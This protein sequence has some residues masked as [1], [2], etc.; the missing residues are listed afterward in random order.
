[1]IETMLSVQGIR[2]SYGSQAVLH[3]VSLHVERSERLLLIGANGCG[4]TTLLKVIAG[5][6]RPE[7]GTVRLEGRDITRLP[8]DE[9]MRE[10]MGFLLQARNIFPSLSV[11]ENMLLAFWNGNDKFEER[12]DCLLKAF[13]MIQNKL[14]RRAGL[15]SGG[16]RQALA[17]AMTLMRPVDVL[18][19]DEP[20]AGLAPKAA[21][22]ILDAIRVVQ[23]SVGFTTIMVEHNLRAV[24]RWVSRFVAMKHGKI[25]GEESDVSKLLDHQT[26]QRYYFG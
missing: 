5:A 4:K 15:L 23:A 20:T 9:R 17:I 14:N 13:P 7:A 16:E 21:A 19:L 25:V 1:M 8:E 24:H 2:A 12:R 3:D 26:M 10:G 22:V 6:L 18:L 11:E